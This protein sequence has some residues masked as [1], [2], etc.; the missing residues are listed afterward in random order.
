[1]RR[2]PPRRKWPSLKRL[3]ADRNG[4]LVLF[5]ACLFVVTGA[6][7]ADQPF[8]VVVTANSTH[9]MANDKP[10]GTVYKGTRLTVSQTKGDSYLVDV[11]GFN[12]PKQGWIRKSDVQPSAKGVIAPLTPEQRK[13]RLKEQDRLDKESTKLRNAGKFDEAIAAAEKMLVIEREVYG[14]DYPDTASYVSWLAMLHLEKGD[15]ADARKLCEEVLATQTR[16]FGKDSWQVTDAR[17]ALGDVAVWTKLK[18]E[19]RQSLVHCDV[20]ANQVRHLCMDGNAASALPLA[21]EVFR[22]RTRILGKND[23]FTSFAESWLGVIYSDL[24]HPAEAKQWFSRAVEDQRTILGEM[25]PYYAENVGHLAYQY[26]QMGEYAKAEPLY[27]RSAEIYK[28]TSGEQV[29]YGH[30]L[31]NLAPL[32]YHMGRYAEAGPLFERSGHSQKG[33]W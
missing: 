9:V 10:I 5:A 8:D 20:L 32:Y 22:T 30:C 19:D 11:P 23:R 2:A 29:D 12:G 7:L 6:A 1:M 31:N 33:D 25:H 18:P 4:R 14:N 17:L 27:K 21:R 3:I 15:F 16:L 13:T 26:E 28:A 24:A